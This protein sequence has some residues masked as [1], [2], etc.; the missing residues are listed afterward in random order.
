MRIVLIGPKVVRASLRHLG[1]MTPS[2]PLSASLVMKLLEQRAHLDRRHFTR[3]RHDRRDRVALAVDLPG[4]DGRRRRAGSALTLGPGRSRSALF[5]GTDDQLPTG[6]RGHE[7]VVV[8][9]QNLLIY[10]VLPE[11]RL[12]LGV[13][14]T[15]AI[16]T[17][18]NSDGLGDQQAT[19]KASGC[20]VGQLRCPNV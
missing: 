12:I 5:P 15:G 18:M 2:R 8:P 1:W 7:R 16:V 9:L 19:P 4:E 17:R 20:C 13:M 10:R 14:L 11:R 3:I 6:M